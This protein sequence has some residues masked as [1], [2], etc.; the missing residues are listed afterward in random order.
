MDPVAA[1]QDAIIAAGLSDSFRSAIQNNPN[2]T[3]D[4]RNAFEESVIKYS[5]LQ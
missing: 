5:G 1:Q 2:I 4:I 3:Q